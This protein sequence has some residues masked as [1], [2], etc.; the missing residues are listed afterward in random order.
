MGVAQ[1]SCRVG[2]RVSCMGAWG[3]GPLHVLPLCFCCLL[4]IVY[5]IQ[6]DFASGFFVVERGVAVVSGA[7]WP[8]TADGWALVG[9]WAQGG[10]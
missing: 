2:G 1:V 7:G 5:T 8:A 4:W 3:V 10:E 9:G 6:G